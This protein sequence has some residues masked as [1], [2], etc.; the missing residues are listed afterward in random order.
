MNNIRI[1]AIDWGKKRIGLAISDPFNNYAIPLMPLEN[2]EKI[3]I[4]I[5]QKVIE[6]KISQIVIGFPLLSNNEEST[7]CKIIKDFS[8]KLDEEFKNQKLDISIVFQNEFYSTKNAKIKITEFVNNRKKW[9]SF[10]DSYSALIILEDY[11]SNIH[12]ERSKK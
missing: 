9:E 4:S 7:L 5:T 6:Y 11:L 3:F 10:K 12:N 8:E 1:L 2:N